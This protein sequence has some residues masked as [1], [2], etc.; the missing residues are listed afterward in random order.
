VTDRLKLCVTMTPGRN[1]RDSLATILELEQAGIDIVGVPEAYGID[2]VSLLGFLAG[3]TERVQLLS[4]IL[5]I[6]SRT[7]TL[8]AM[9]AVGLDF[10][11]GGRFILG[12]GASGPQVVEGWHGVPYQAPIART[13]EVIEICRAVWRRDRLDHHGPHYDMPLPPDQGTGLGKPLKLIDTPIRERIPIYLAALGEKNVEL[14]AECADGWI[15]V[16]YIPEK[17]DLVWGESLATGAAKR[18]SSL[19][20]LEIIAG[21]MFA[22]GDDVVPRRDRARAQL[23]LYVGGMGARGRNFYNNIVQRYGWTDAARLVQD[24]YLDGKRAEAEAALPEGLVEGATLIGDEAYV[25]DRLRAYVASG[26]TTLV[27][28]PVG[29]EPLTE[30]RRLRELVELV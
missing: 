23:A 4:D 21:G 27:V 25:L 13:R 8:T 15:P 17:A 26:A 12:L 18:D 5:P 30:I 22:L 16:F 1:V 10:V 24:L 6:Y 11:S 20:P 14:T 3:R 2:A 9:T 19:G 7:P 29:P 28:D